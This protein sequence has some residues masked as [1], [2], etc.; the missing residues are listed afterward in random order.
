MKMKDRDTPAA[1]GAAGSSTRAHLRVPV[2]VFVRVVGADR[3][4]PFRT[5]DLSEGGIF[6]NTRV[7]HLYPFAV[8]DA[9]T[10][11]LHDE[12]HVLTLEGEI[13]RAVRE[14]TDGTDRGA[15]FAVRIVRLTD[16]QREGLRALVLRHRSG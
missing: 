16:E 10:I 11:E 12:A 8:G 7:G 2:D 6:L 15:G 14:G 5:R 1:A 4:Y 9:L 13:V 3:D